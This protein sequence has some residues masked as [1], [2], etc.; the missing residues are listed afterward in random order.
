MGMEPNNA[1]VRPLDGVLKYVRKPDVAKPVQDT[2]SRDIPHL[3]SRPWAAVEDNIVEDLP[4]AVRRTVDEKWLPMEIDN[5]ELS[6]IGEVFDVVVAWAIRHGHDENTTGLEKLVR[7]QESA[8][9]R[10]QHMLEDV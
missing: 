4:V 8:L 3:K 10:R 2:F 1:P 7:P 5:F 6:K 9:Q